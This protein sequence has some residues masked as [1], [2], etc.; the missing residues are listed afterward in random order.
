MPFPTP[1][2]QLLTGGLFSARK[3][4]VQAPS[5][6]LPN[7]GNRFTEFYCQS[8]G[9][10]LNSG[11]DTNTG[12][13]YTSAAGN[14]VSATRV[15]TPT[16]GVNPALTIQVGDFASVYLTAGAVDTAFVGR[17]SAVQNVVNGTITIDNVAKFG[18]A[19]A[20]GTG[21]ITLKVGG[22]WKGPNG[23]SGFPFSAGA[24]TAITD[25]TGNPVRVNMKNTSSYTPT[26]AFNWI[27]GVVVQGYT[28][29]PGDGGRAK[30][31]MGS[32]SFTITMANLGWFLVD[33]E[34]LSSTTTGNTSLN[35]MNTGGIAIR[36]VWH[37]SRG[38][39]VNFAGV[40]NYIFLECEFY[41]NN[42][43]NTTS[44]IINNGN[45]GNVYLNNCYIHD[46]LGTL[47]NGVNFVGSAGGSAFIQNSIFAHNGGS[48]I[49]F[50]TQNFTVVIMNNDFYNN[51]GDG[52]NFSLASNIVQNNNFVKNGGRGINIT[53]SNVSGWL[54]NNGYGS[55]TQAN[56]GGD[57]IG[58]YIKINSI[59]YA[60]DVTP[61]N[62]PDTGDFRIVLPSAIGTGR[63]FFLETDGVN[64]GT[65]GFPDMGAAQST[66]GPGGLSG[67][68][69]TLRDGYINH[70]YSVL[71]EWTLIITVSI[72]AGALPPGLSLIQPTTSSYLISGTPTTLGSYSATLTYVNSVGATTTGQIN[73][74][75]FDDPD[76]GAGAVGGG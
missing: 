18:G 58:D 11:S 31:D 48:G 32:N 59:L 63:G 68:I 16:D 62:A 64:S 2:F 65:I 70:A 66:G 3:P 8:T 57:I 73:I 17:I 25:V 40:G 35:A 33:L 72:T 54:Y 45:Q 22:A 46:N 10:N 13:R 19:P 1:Y 24:G 30:I 74:T 60:P 75:V 27:M 61:W 12:A 51:G 71:Q 67:T 44:G 38:N 55:G 76:E 47:S 37:G 39:A 41:G 6:P 69:S 4:H 26:A 14:W 49:K 36:C 43:S 29:S 53:V 50:G 15:F 7:L 42:T 23:A 20:D 56:G 28:S 52:I 21:T 5:G 9:S 34:F